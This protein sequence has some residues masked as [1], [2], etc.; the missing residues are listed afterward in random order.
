ME[1]WGDADA[2][3]EGQGDGRVEEQKSGT[4]RW[5]PSWAN[6]LRNNRFYVDQSDI[7]ILRVPL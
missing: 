7:L 5:N 6:T 4:A 3:L 2:E 1:S